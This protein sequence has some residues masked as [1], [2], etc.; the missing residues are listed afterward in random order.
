M[1]VMLYELVTGVTPFSGGSAAEIMSGHLLHDPPPM[2]EAGVRRPVPEPIVRLVR[3]ALSKAPAERP[4]AA[5]FALALTADGEPQPGSTEPRGD[6]I[7]RRIQR[8]FGR[9]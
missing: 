7:V 1:G 3:A 4:T 8:L 2:A 5:A 9:A 6:G